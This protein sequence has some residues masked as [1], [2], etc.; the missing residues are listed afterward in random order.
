MSLL[1]VNFDIVTGLWLFVFIAA[2]VIEIQ[3]PN[4]TTVWFAAGAFVVILLSLFTSIGLTLQVI[5]F[6]AVS[7]VLLLT[8]RKWSQ[9]LL[10]SGSAIKT[11]IDNAI[12]Q[13]VIVTKEVNNLELGECEYNNLTWTI[14]S[15]DG[16]TILK[17]EIAVIVDVEGNKFIVTKKGGNK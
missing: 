17:N 13:E 5:V 2:I 8:L 10:K 4:L 15:K 16:I 11:N 3:T 12:G 14:K 7:L 1:A 6:I 9:K